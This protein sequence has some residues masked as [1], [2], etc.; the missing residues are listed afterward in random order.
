M[1]LMKKSSVILQQTIAGV[2]TKMEAN[3]LIPN[4]KGDQNLAVSWEV[5]MNNHIR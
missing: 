2:L 4:S 5:E 3:F 1:V